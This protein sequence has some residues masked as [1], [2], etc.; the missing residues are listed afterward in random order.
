[1]TDWKRLLHCERHNVYRVKEGRIVES[2][3]GIDPGTIRAQQLGQ[4]ELEVGGNAHADR[5]H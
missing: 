1:M 4:Q 3:L 5:S 2:W